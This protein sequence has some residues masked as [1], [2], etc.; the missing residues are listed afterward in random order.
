MRA[1]LWDGALDLECLTLTLEIQ[2]AGLTTDDKQEVSVRKLQKSPR[3]SCGRRH[4]QG[5][6]TQARKAGERV[7][8]RGSVTLLLACVSSPVKC[9]CY[10]RN[11]TKS[12]YQHYSAQDGGYIPRSF[13]LK[14]SPTQTTLPPGILSTNSCQDER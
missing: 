12:F 14:V 7:S 1:A 13:H 2:G 5:A 8:S 6:T 11:P 9:R 10:T 4:H 3:M